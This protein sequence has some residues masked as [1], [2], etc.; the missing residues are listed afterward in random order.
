MGVWPLQGE[1]TLYTVVG[2]SIHIKVKEHKVMAHTYRRADRYTV[3]LPTTLN[4]EV[5]RRFD[6][7]ALIKSI[8]KL[9]EYG[10]S[11]KTSKT[12]KQVIVD[13]SASYHMISDTK[14]F[15]NVKRKLGNV[16]IAN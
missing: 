5:M 6:F 4:D 9:G 14:L 1:E 13:S 15:S 3:S 10:K 16:I 12:Q 2:F 7:E 11:F 8:V